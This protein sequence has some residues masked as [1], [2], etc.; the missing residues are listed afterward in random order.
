[1]KIIKS[2]HLL[3][4]DRVYK[5]KEI[6]TVLTG[7]GMKKMLT[8]CN[9]NLHFILNNEVYV[10]N[11]GFTMGYPIEPILANAFMVELEN[12]LVLTLHRHIKK[13][14]RFVVHTFAYVENESVDYFLTTLNSFHPD[15]SFTYEKQNNTQL[16]Y[17]FS[18]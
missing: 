11:D 12:T 2:F 6:S 14:R 5:L 18:F 8:L 17:V 4:L 10:K 13:W 16:L 3:L 7:D 15:I 9:K 1:M